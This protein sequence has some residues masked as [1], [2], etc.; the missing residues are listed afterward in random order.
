MEDGFEPESVPVMNRKPCPNSSNFPETLRG[1]LRH[2]G[3]TTHYLV[4][5]AFALVCGQLTQDGGKLG[6][7][8]DRSLAYLLSVA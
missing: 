6:C 5:A 4:K 7:E 8:L 1:V 2:F 3:N